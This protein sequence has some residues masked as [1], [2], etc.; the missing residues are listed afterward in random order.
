MTND[1]IITGIPRS[2]TSYLCSILNRNR[3]TVVIN[4]PEEIFR[5]L[6]N[7]SDVPLSRYYA[8]IRSRINNGQPIA[9]KMVNGKFIEDTNLLDAR[10]A[11]TPHVDTSDFVLGTKNTLI[12][13]NTLKRITKSL[14]EAVLVACVRHPCD[15]IASWGKVSFPHIRDATPRFLL[16]YTTGEENLSI[17]RILKTTELAARYAMWWDYLAG[18][19]NSN[20]DRFIV[21]NYEHMVS[22]PEATLARIYATM[23]FQAE[24]QQPLEP[25]APRHHENALD[26][27]IVYAINDKCKNSAALLGYNL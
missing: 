23:P 12:Y 10:T 22:D 11:Y 1:L 27:D 4:E 16:N 5:V 26:A 14:P 6:R 9:N 15:T 8:H 20:R 13:L 24:P 18:I 7:D 3:N 17:D 25:S 19:I 2:G 21:I